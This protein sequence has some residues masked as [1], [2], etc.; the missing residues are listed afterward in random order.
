MTTDND[1]RDA[2]LDFSVRYLNKPTEEVNE[3]IF[4]SIAKVVLKIEP[5]DTLPVPPAGSVAEKK[6]FDIKREMGI[7]RNMG[8]Q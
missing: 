2:F 1:L 8:I 3:K 7:E 4:E 5:D 6:I